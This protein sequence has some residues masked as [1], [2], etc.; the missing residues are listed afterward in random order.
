MHTTPISWPSGDLV[1][2]LLGGT[3]LNYVGNR[4]CLRGASA[5]ASEERKHVKMANLDKQKELSGGQ[6]GNQ[7]H[8]ATMI[9]AWLS[10][11]L[12]GLNDT[13]LS[14]ENARMW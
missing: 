2:S 10:A 6:E 7:L 4:E 1:D 12:H 9:E 14:Q 11:V 3:A 13:E 8:T 5:G